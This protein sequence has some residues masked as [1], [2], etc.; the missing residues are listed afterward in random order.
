MASSNYYL[1]QTPEEF[2]NRASRYFYGESRTTDGFLKITKVDLTQTSDSVSLQNLNAGVFN[3]N[4]VPDFEEGV[5][6]FD[7]VDATT[8][9]PNYIG[10][11]F[12]QYKWTQ[13]D[14]YYYVDGD[15]VLSVRVDVPYG[16]TEGATFQVLPEILLTNSTAGAITG[17]KILAGGY[18]LGTIIGNGN[19]LDNTTSAN[20]SFISDKETT[21]YKLDMGTIA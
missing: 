18:D 1:G 11:N 3:S 14:L 15:G 19:P 21:T 5:D 2:L 7:G 6:F 10:I 16:Y 8:K 13:D 20:L 17:Q 12:E 4:S 9:M